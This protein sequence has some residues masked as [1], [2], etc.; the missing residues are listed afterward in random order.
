MEPSIRLSMGGMWSGEEEVR[1]VFVTD[2][3]GKVS[4]PEQVNPGSPTHIFNTFASSF[5]LILPPL[6]LSLSGHRSN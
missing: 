2:W 5:P 6:L 1:L 4:V 3:E